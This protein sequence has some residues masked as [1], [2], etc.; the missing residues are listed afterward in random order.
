MA[1]SGTTLPFSSPR[2]LTPDRIALAAV[3]AFASVVTLPAVWWLDEAR[4]EIGQSRPAMGAV[5]LST[6][7]LSL[8]LVRRALRASSLGRAA[9]WCI[10]GA[11]PAGVVNAG[12]CLSAVEL[13]RTGDPGAAFGG[14]FLGIFVGG[15]YG[16]PIGLGYGLAYAV[17]VV[18]ALQARET[19]AHDASDRALFGA[20]A[21]LAVVGS[22]LA[23][24][25][26][27]APSLIPPVAAAAAGIGW[28]AIAGVRIAARRRWLE[29]VGEG[30][31]LAFRIEPRAW[32]DEERALLPVVRSGVLSL[33]PE[34]VVTYKAQF[35]SD[36]YRESPKG[37]PVALADLPEPRAAARPVESAESGRAARAE[38]P[39]VEIRGF[40]SRGL[41]VMAQGAVVM[42]VFT[43]AA[44]AAAVPLA[45]ILAAFERIANIQ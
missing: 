20:G 21:W 28:L 42:L 6:I 35:A 7:G 14:L 25:S 17:V 41:E 10:L 44:M 26:L 16:A 40:V 31:E 38:R 15:F 5:I 45:S 1:R 37:T 34:G 24:A 33:E 13:I 19:R 29:R 30:R 11:I 36:P 4:R 18:T 2:Y 3:A 43:V 12:L 39:G 27:G 9:L 22:A 23:V 32:S 8:L